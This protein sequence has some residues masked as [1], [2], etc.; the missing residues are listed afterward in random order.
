[1]DGHHGGYGGHGCHDG[2]DL[3]TKLQITAGAAANGT[4][5]QFSSGN[6]VSNRGTNNNADASDSMN[7]STCNLFSTF[8]SFPPPPPPPPP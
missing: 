4:D 8:S 7:N 2:L 3:K 5:E 1:H 6:I